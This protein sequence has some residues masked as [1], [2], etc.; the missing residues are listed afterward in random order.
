MG[1]HLGGEGAVCGGQIGKAPGR[2]REPISA[3]AG[4]DQQVCGLASLQA[5]EERRV[6]LR[7]AGRKQKRREK[8]R[9]IWIN[10]SFSRLFDAGC[11]PG[12]NIL[13]KWAAGGWTI[14]GFL[15]Y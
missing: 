8:E 12:K 13:E 15:L 6:S 10:R 9:F 7:P 2:G 1:R 11:G 5:A 4:A 3:D 14:L